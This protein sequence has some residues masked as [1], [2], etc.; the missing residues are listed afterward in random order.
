MH[1]VRLPQLV[2]GHHPG[3]AGKISG[4]IFR[5]VIFPSLGA[6]R[7]EILVGPQ[8][9][10]DAGVVDLGAGQVMAIST[11]PFFV[12]PDVGWQRA[13]WFAVHIVAS[14]VAVSGLRP[15]YFVVDL[16]LPL[17]LPDEELSALWE[18]VARACGD[19]GM[20]IVAGHTARYDDC[21]FPVI[22]A[23]TAIGL[24]SIE[25]Y[26]TPGMA[27]VGDRILLTKGAAIEATGILGVTF[28]D[29]IAQ[30]YGPE[31]ARDAEALFDQMS[32][33]RDAAVAVQVGVHHNGVTVMHD[34]TERGVWGALSEIAAASR[35]GM[36][37]DQDTIH[38]R[39]E[40]RAV[41]DLFGIDPYTAS[42]EGTLLLT[43]RPHR[44][45]ELIA[46]L[47]EAEI[48]AFCIGEITPAKAGSKI[49]HG[50]REHELRAPRVDPFWPAYLKAREGAD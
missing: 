12:L 26:V 23:A 41:C 14:D 10:V 17:T 9:G 27:E 21:S 33:V 43:C 15:R 20:S 4:E 35:V 29:R 19:M 36:T 45:E 48:P 5:Q 37:V 7:P 1:K 2:T 32:V 38:I 39:P 34:A 44:T 50:G 16:N 25:T 24:G 3:Q 8:H 18:A 42:S 40:V 30:V 22:G 49:S 6:E 31:T 46:R 28:K 13:A 11:D 47:G